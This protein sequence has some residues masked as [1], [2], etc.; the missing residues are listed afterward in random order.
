MTELGKGFTYGVGLDQH[1]L[2]IGPIG[3]FNGI[4][5]DGDT[6]YCILSRLSLPVPRRLPADSRMRSIKLS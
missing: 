3:I 6:H 4:M 1:I 2:L 5:D